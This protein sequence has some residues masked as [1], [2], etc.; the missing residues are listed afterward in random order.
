MG[1]QRPD[2]SCFQGDD[3]P[4]DAFVDTIGGNLQSLIL[5]A[6]LGFPVCSEAREYMLTQWLGGLCMVL[7]S[8]RQVELMTEAERQDKVLPVDIDALE[9]GALEVVALLP[10]AIRLRARIMREQVPT[11]G[12]A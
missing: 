1:T 9:R 3:A 8:E 2:C 10:E 4:A 7:E 11:E 5:S 6:L 12:H